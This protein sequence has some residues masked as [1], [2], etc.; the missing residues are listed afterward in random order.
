[1]K[2][3]N[4]YFYSGSKTVTNNICNNYSNFGVF[5]AHRIH[6]IRNNSEPKQWYYVHSVH[7]CINHP[8]KSLFFAKPLL[9]SNLPTVKASPPFL[10]NF[11]LYIVF[12]VNLP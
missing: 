8:Q 7:W 1:M 5:A 9:P 6:E 4:V 11:P 10:R 2:V 3:D 12:F